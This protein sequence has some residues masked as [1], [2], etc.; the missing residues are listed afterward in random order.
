MLKVNRRFGGTCLLHLQGRKI[1]HTRNQ[2][3]AVTFS[4]RK[5]EATF[6]PESLVPF[7]QITWRYIAQ[8]STLHNH[9]CENLK[10]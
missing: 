4:T 9:L 8:D 7:Q 1:S 3:K 2:N 6:P 10:S 5:M